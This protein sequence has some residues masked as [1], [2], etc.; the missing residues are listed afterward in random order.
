M[1]KFPHDYL[2]GAGRDL[3]ALYRK[4]LARLEVRLAPMLK[5]IQGATPTEIAIIRSTK[6]WQDGIQ[7]LKADVDKA[8]KM[9][10][11]V[12][13]KGLNRGYRG[14][15]TDILY[16]AESF[17]DTNLAAIRRQ[18]GKKALD[19]INENIPGRPNVARVLAGNAVSS[20]VRVAEKIT[21]LLTQPMTDKQ[22][23]KALRQVVTS[24]YTRAARVL[25]SEGTRV[26]NGAAVDV[27]ATLQETVIEGVR[28]V[29][30]L[31]LVWIH[32]E[33]L[34]PRPYHRDVLH[35]SLP[36]RDGY[37][38]EADG[39]KARGPGMFPSIEHNAGCRCTLDLMEY[40]EWL[41]TFGNLQP[42]S[43]DPKDTYI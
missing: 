23:S 20:Q 25:Q 26:V 38:H 22:F 30:G 41:S 31:V 39:E 10:A 12:I 34:T 18:A 42:W 13:G 40:T 3:A 28:G 32:D 21:Q 9:R 17:A 4:L 37:W 29:P 14:K 8:I 11:E 1:T 16:Q 7:A 6:E 36:D 43:H 27:F 33:P 19:R 35:G 15:Y 5:R 2:D 24:D